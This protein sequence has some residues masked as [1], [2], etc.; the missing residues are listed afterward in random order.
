MNAEKERRIAEDGK[1]PMPLSPEKKAV[2]DVLQAT[3]EKVEA[4][5]AISSTSASNPDVA[6]GT[7]AAPGTS[8]VRRAS[9][10]RK[11]KGG[12]TLM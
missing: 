3:V 9:S 5:E 12:C 6:A 11:K 10:G 4:S 8:A 2:H 7:S 1:E